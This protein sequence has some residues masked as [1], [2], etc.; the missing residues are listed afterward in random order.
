[1]TSVVE[2]PP[3]HSSEERATTPHPVEF[4]L[5]ANAVLPVLA[6]PTSVKPRFLDIFG[7]GIKNKYATASANVF[8][9]GYQYS[10]TI[11]II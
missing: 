4:P 2:P 7:G 8:V 5:I 9:L 11:D 6:S 10:T 3:A 1:M